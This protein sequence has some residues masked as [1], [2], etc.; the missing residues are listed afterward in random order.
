LHDS[1]EISQI[2]ERQFLTMLTPLGYPSTQ[3]HGLT[4]VFR[5]QVSARVGSQ[6][7]RRIALRHGVTPFQ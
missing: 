2:N 3:R 6:G 4:D 1:G 7:R 5:A